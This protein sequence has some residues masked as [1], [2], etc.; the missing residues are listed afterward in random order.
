[1]NEI[2][3]IHVLKSLLLVVVAVVVS[4]CW[5][6]RAEKDMVIGTVRS[7]V[8][9]LA[10]GYALKY[11]FE[12]DLLILNILVVLVMVTVA[13]Y[14][15]SSRIHHLSR[16]FPL[17]MIALAVGAMGT[18]FSLMI[19]NPDWLTARYIIP[20][21]G[22]I[23]SNSMNATTLSVSR[24]VSD[25]RSNRLE[26]ETSL[27]LGKSWHIA[28]KNYRREATVTGMISILNFMKTVGLVALPGAMTGMILGG[29]EPL[30][31]VLLQLV[32]AYMLLA[33]TAVTSV[34]AVELTVRKFFT[35]H[36]QL[37]IEE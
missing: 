33:A 10:V 6:V 22:M 29:A 25:I 37:V 12:P 15:A 17:C 31:A 16:P 8:Q 26:I 34:V 32:V 7:F 14:T 2:T 36:H 13:G 19:I 9:L 4:R 23:I 11:I 5:K 30:E 20:L 28:T 3:Y 24:L 1:M 21:G 18:L 35:T 27:S